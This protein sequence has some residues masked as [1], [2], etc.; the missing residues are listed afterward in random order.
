MP[1]AQHPV[2]LYVICLSMLCAFSACAPAP[3]MLDRAIVRNGTS[4]TIS[5]VTV[6]HEPTN[7]MGH[8]SAILPQS[9][10]DLGFTRQPLKGKRAVVTWTTEGMRPMSVEV[11]LPK[12]QQHSKDKTNHTFT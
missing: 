10:L 7:A 6:R 9:E 1:R 3:I 5:D 11:L 4:N 2:T 8:V 12:D